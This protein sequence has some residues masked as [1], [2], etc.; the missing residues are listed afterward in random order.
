MKA[1]YVLTMALSL[2]TGLAWAKKDCTDADRGQ[3]MSEEAFKAKLEK[4]GYQIDKFKQPGSCYEIYGK[5]AKGQQVE[6]YFDPV[7]AEIKKMEI[8]DDED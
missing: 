1:N 3:W 4:E 5:N 7:T 6:I 8:E 2:I